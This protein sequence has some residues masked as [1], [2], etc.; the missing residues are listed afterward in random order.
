MN[1]ADLAA[2]VQRAKGGEAEAFGRLVSEFRAELLSHV[3]RRMSP[4]LRRKTDEEDIVQSAAREAF[5]QFDGFE[6][7]G[8]SSLRNWLV[9]I[10]ER[11]LSEVRKHY[12]SRKRSI[13][14]EASI[15]ESIRQYE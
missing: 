2:L 9:V 4:A 5:E 6:L 11:K 13:R 14:R 8:P 10:A 3:R 7:R 15:A 12:Q 1:A